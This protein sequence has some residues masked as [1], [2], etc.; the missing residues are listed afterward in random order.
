MVIKIRAKWGRWTP[1][2]GS[3]TDR[4]FLSRSRYLVRGTAQV[5]TPV[6]RSRKPRSRH[7]LVQKPRV[8][9]RGDLMPGTNEQVV[10]LSN[11]TCAGQLSVCFQT[12]PPAFSLLVQYLHCSL[13]LGFW[14][15]LV[16]GRR[17]VGDSGTQ[18]REKRGYLSPAN[19]WCSL[20]GLGAASTVALSPGIACSNLACSHFEIA[21][22]LLCG[23]VYY[24]SREKKEEF[25][26]CRQKF[27]SVLE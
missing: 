21:L 27:L 24:R 20:R 18:S 25:T 22:I 14:V 19:L 11:G 26:L 4:C 23:Q 7:P 8:S 2:I 13:S 16:S 10:T 5:Y 12:N 15:D 3:V 1:V 9:G 6:P 17:S